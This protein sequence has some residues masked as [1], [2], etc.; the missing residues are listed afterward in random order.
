[1]IV[2]QRII[3]Y[4]FY[5]RVYEYVQTEVQRKSNP[6]GMEQNKKENNRVAID[7]CVT[8][9]S[10]QWN[11]FSFMI[12]SISTRFD[13]KFPSISLILTIWAWIQ[14][15]DFQVFKDAKNMQIGCN[16]AKLQC[17]YNCT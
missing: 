7:C 12:S 6:N 9:Y 4:A 16:Q 5:G 2:A 1:M 3:V 11:T 14:S 17:N 8:S 13:G 10:M 15:S